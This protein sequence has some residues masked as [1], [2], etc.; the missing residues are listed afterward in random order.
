MRYDASPFFLT[1]WVRRL[2]V[3]NGIVYLLQLTV[4][5]SPWLVETFGFRPAAVL[6]HPWSVL[7]YAFLHGD[8][9][10]I[11]FNMLALFMFGPMVEDR[12]G[13]TRF[14]RLYAISALGGAALSLALLPLTGD[15]VIIGASGAI[16]GVMLAFVFEWPD[17]PIYVFPLPVPV[18]AKWLVMFFAAVNI[19]PLVLQVHDGVAHLAHLG[20][21]A[22]A[23]LYLRGGT[24]LAGARRRTPV[25]SSAAVLVHPSAFQ[26]ARRAG[27]F[28][29]R[30][31]SADARA[32]EEV[33]RVLDKISAGGLSS[34]TAEERRFLDEMS[35]RFKQEH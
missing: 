30:R 13:G 29:G 23:F 28:G 31:R 16:F 3:A 4:F 20:G 35:K 8:F 11:F 25:T 1:R 19:L 34:L 12:L 6:R 15:S 21:F 33:N 14:A 32:L 26:T 10:H 2:L 5:T 9:L 17:A 24:L 27:P 18:K 7:T 22:A